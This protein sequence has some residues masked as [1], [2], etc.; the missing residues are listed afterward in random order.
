M[1]TILIIGLA[2]M[3]AAPAA[4]WAQ[5]DPDWTVRDWNDGAARNDPAPTDPGWREPEWET[6]ARERDWIEPPWAED[7]AAERDR[8][9]PASDEGDPRADDRSERAWDERDPSERTW[10]DRDRSERAS[11]ERTRREFGWTEGE[12]APILTSPLAADEIPPVEELPADPD[13]AGHDPPD[14]SSSESVWDDRPLQDE[15]RA[16]ESAGRPASEAAPWDEPTAPVP[17]APRAR[18]MAPWGEVEPPPA[19]PSRSRDREPPVPWP[20]D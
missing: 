17:T 4:A 15:A 13:D 12:A 6:R 5:T 14:E 1:R 8:S 3:L 10:E 20:R 18:P 16:A 11:G 7:A 9:E 19:E 2:A